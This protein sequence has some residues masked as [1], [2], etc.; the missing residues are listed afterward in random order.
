MVYVG[1]YNKLDNNFFVILVFCFVFGNNMYFF[2]DLMKIII[3]FI[4]YYYEI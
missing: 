4:Y 2:G 1:F 3:Y